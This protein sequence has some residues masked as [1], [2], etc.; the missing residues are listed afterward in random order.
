MFERDRAASGA[1]IVLG[2]VSGGRAVA[3]MKVTEEMANAHGIGHGGYVFLLADV[4]FSY[5]CN[6]YGPVALAQGAQVTFL[7]PAQL[8][9]E[10]V[11]EAVERTLAG[12][13]G[14]YDVTVRTAAGAVVA[15]FRGQSVLVAGVPHSG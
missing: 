6:S 11:A 15:E 7:A 8:G 13:Q 3:R 12:R 4:A 1:G 5:A 14:V 9:D 2:E 10:L